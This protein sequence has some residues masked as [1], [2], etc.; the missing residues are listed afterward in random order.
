MRDTE[1]TPA[2]LRLL[3][4]GVSLR[5]GAGGEGKIGGDEGW[6]GGGGWREEGCFSHGEGR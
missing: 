1:R 3:L 5:G 6:W 4:V 2:G